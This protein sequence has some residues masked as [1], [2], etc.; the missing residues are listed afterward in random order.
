M[1][2]SLLRV[3]NDVHEP[4]IMKE[5]VRQRWCVAIS[6]IIYVEDNYLFNLSSREHCIYVTF[7]F[8][9]NFKKN[10]IFFCRPK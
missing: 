9:P 4:S 3:N 5:G 2:N 10:V 1:I 7:H 6:L 8:D